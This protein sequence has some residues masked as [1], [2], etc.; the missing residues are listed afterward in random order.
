MTYWNLIL[1]V[2]KE[3]ERNT[4]LDAGMQGLRNKQFRPLAVREGKGAFCPATGCESGY[5][6]SPARKAGRDKK[7]R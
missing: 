2:E 5:L 6:Q 1:V 7:N 4:T 3:K